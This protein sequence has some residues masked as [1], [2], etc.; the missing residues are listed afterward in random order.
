MTAAK[1]TPA[2][3][4]QCEEMP[5]LVIA[6]NSTQRSGEIAIAYVYDKD[7]GEETALANARV[8][9]LAPEML[10]VLEE[11]YECNI[12]HVFDFQ[13]TQEMHRRIHEIIA[14]A[15]GKTK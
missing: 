4:V 3:W 11:I 14:E 7:V 15:K 5:H 13:D 8:M 9:A 12:L 10:A 6:K 1:H 2:P